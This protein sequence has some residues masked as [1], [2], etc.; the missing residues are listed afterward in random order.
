[1]SVCSA[2]SPTEMLFSPKEREASTHQADHKLL[3]MEKDNS[4]SPSESSDALSWWQT[5][6]LSLLAPARRATSPTPFSWEKD[7][8][9]PTP[10]VVGRCWAQPSLMQ[11][12]L[13][14]SQ[15]SR[16]AMR[17]GGNTL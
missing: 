16:W 7:G 11:E 6:L 17:S 1:M 2:L 4:Y 5:G 8:T 13:L 15:A 12:H 9:L 3:A 10:S 14:P